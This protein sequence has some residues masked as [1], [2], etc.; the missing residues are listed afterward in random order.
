MRRMRCGVGQFG[1][2]TKRLELPG[3][4]ILIS[5]K[6]SFVLKSSP[7]VILKRMVCFF[8]YGYIKN[9]GVSEANVKAAGKYLMK[10]KDYEVADGD[11]ILFVCIF[12]I[13]RRHSIFRDLILPEEVVRKN[14]CRYL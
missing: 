3:L 8:F 5:K 12:L 10:G 7:I 2:D 13:L 11:V 6:V 14:D 4:F 1:K 9:E